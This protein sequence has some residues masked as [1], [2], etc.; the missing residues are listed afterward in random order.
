MKRFSQIAPLILKV[1]APALVIVA[2]CM[3]G[4]DYHPPATSAPAAWAGITNVLTNAASIATTNAGDLARWWEKFGDPKLSALVQEALR[5]NLDVQLAQA[6]LRQA[7][8]ARGVV[9]GGLWPGL[10]GTAAYARTGAGGVSQNSYQAGLDALWELD[11]FG[12]IRR[13]LESANANIQAAREN[14]RDVQVTLISEVAVNYIQLRSFQEQID[15][16]NENLKSEQHTADLT[17]QKLR[18][19]FV[20]GLDLANA[21]AQVATTASA[22]PVL[23]ISLQQNIYALSVLLAR[24]PADL[25]DDLS[26]SGPV[27][28]TPPDVPV[29][30]PSDLLR[31][32]PDIREA[33][34]QLHAATAQIGVAVS[35][36]FPQFSL[37]GS[38]NA[39]SDLLR[40]WFA[41]SSRLWNVG[42]SMTW[43]IFQGGSLVSNIRV[44]EALRDQAGITYR[45]TVLS[46]LQDV[47]NGLIAFAKEWEHRKVLNDAVNYNRRALD[48]STQLYTQ[49]TTDFLSVLDAERS[50]FASQTALAQSKA[51]IST[52]LVALYKALGGGWVDQ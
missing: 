27:P 30:L 33:E 47:E 32:R 13:N 1:A 26:K 44:Q 7:R 21:N 29:G 19:G 18:V 16:A 41:G 35:A 40:D 8:A 43:P 22:I 36:L 15:I 11:I 39:E 6:R 2:G 24:P 9:A 34:A 51:A 42:P 31:R 37:T 50:L 49:G 38:V 28:L 25:L 48:L 20:S 52:D 17:R 12:G 23:Q 3:V 45:K 46:A 14:I 4:P 5:T 10:T